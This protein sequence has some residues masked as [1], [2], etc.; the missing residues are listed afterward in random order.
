[1]SRRKTWTVSAAATSPSRFAVCAASTSSS[2]SATTTPSS[3]GLIVSST[4]KS[5]T[6]R[7]SSSRKTRSS[8][9]DSPLPHRDYTGT[10][11]VGLQYSGNPPVDSR[12]AVVVADCARHRAPSHA[13]LRAPGSGRG[14]MDD[15]QSDY[16]SAPPAVEP[17]SADAAAP[18][19]PSQAL[20]QPPAPYPPYSP[21]APSGGAP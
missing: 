7:P 18:A 5:A 10:C 4:W 1:M 15:H 19:D 20:S 9:P 17:R 6:A 16:P 12:A 2:S 21:Y 8:R 13:V 14:M 11:I 3:R